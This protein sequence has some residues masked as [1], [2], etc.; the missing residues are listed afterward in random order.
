[1]LIGK[2]NCPACMFLQHQEVHFKE[3][4]D[5]AKKQHTCQDMAYTTQERI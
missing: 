2:H 5:G 3:D 4:R 1:M